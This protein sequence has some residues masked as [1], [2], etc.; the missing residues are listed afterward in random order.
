MA[1]EVSEKRDRRTALLEAGRQVLAEKGLEAAKVSDIVARAGV[2]QG[3]F[4]LYFPSK[5]SLV[6]ALVQA[7]NTDTMAEVSEAVASAPSLGAAIDA[8]V[9]AAFT[10]MERFRDV[11]GIVLS[12]STLVEIRVE[13]HRLFDPIVAYVAGMIRQGQADGAI[14]S[15]INPEISARLVIHLIEHAGQECYVFNT[16]TPSIAFITE[17]AQ[18]V[19]NAMGVRDGRGGDR[20]GALLPPA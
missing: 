10:A 9:A 16:E 11:L 20:P 3:T 5:L 19:R 14:Y 18:F 17:V 2:A 7:M 15:Q 6:V 4:Y 8:A 1:A 12:T 13:C